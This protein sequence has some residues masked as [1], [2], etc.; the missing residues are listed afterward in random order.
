MTE[1]QESRSYW[2]RHTVGNGRWL[3]G[4]EMPPGAD[5][6]KLRRGLGRG[7]GD[8]PEMW[9]FYTTLNQEGHKTAWF[10]AEHDALTLFAL[11]QQSQSRPMHRSG[12]GLGTAVRSLR[13]EKDSDIPGAEGGGGKP[14]LDRID[15]VDRR[16]A[17]AAT[18]TSR[19]ELVLHL[20]GLVT[21]LRGAGQGLDYTILHKELANW[22]RPDRAPQIRRKWG[23]QYFFSKT[24]K[25]GTDSVEGDQK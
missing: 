17:A 1:P 19:S 23:S 11:H 5:L 15:A 16:F 20:R 10:A 14:K 6:A 4:S 18:A 7:P 21:Q 2:T 24:T 3:S 8:V 9:R 12:V 22:E 13:G 25:S